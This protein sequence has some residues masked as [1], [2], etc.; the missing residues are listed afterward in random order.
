MGGY[1]GDAEVGIGIVR[2][3]S[4]SEPCGLG[5]NLTTEVGEVGVRWENQ[6]LR[7]ACF[8]EKILA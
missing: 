3:G 6:L 7:K 2:I 4:G 1:F 8:I 5:A